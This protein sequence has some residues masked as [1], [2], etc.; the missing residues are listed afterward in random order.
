MTSTPPEKC[1]IY[2]ISC[3]DPRISDKYIGYTTEFRQCMRYHKEKSQ[4]EEYYMKSTL[5]FEIH[6]NGGWNNWSV[7]VIETVKGRK[8]ALQRKMKLIEEDDGLY[9]T[10]NTHKK[11]LKPV[12]VVNP[13]NTQTIL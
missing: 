4:D 6:N 10:L 2:E 11:S 3:K 13:D 9:Y 7:N 8:K 1:Y 5:Y 12:Y